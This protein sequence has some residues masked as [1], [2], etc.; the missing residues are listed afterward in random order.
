MEEEGGRGVGRSKW[1]E[2]SGMGRGGEG[3]RRKEKRGWG[4]EEMGKM[5]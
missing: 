2:M 3:K 5:R 4:E 1:K